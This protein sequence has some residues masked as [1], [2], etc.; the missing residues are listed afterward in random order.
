MEL[1]T[2][3]TQLFIKFG[4]HEYTIELK[5]HS[6]LIH[7]ALYKGKVEPVEEI[8]GSRNVYSYY[9]NY[10]HLFPQV[11]RVL[12]SLVSQ[13]RPNPK[14]L[15]GIY[16]KWFIT[17]FGKL[18]SKHFSPLFNL[19]HSMAESKILLEVDKIC[20]HVTY[21]ACP[22]R[23]EI[24]KYIEN[25]PDSDFEV[26][27][28]A[29]P[30]CVVTVCNFSNLLSTLGLSPNRNEGLYD[31]FGIGKYGFSQSEH[32]IDYTKALCNWKVFLHPSL[33]YYSDPVVKSKVDS[34]ISYHPAQITKMSLM[35]VVQ[36]NARTPDTI[37]T[38]RLPWFL[39]G[40][41]LSHEN[42]DRFVGLKETE[43]L[44]GKKLFDQLYPTLPFPD[45]RLRSKPRSS[46][47]W[48]E[49]VEYLFSYP[50]EIPFRDIKSVFSVIGTYK[51][52]LTLY[53]DKAKEY[54][55]QNTTDPFTTALFS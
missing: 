36:S 46:A 22:I 17:K 41:V 47:R 26:D 23:E 9:Y 48:S 11:M 24:A 55:A 12:A 43:I 50:D 5:P 33:M 6:S 4:K 52:H 13:D 3:Y 28:F 44:K 27:F 10:N 35:N 39:S 20:F 49:Y 16:Q 1:T 40:H 53:N 8:S 21:E 7:F 15:E 37:P 25:N 38:N 14:I 2:A 34:I 31:V 42:Y 30:V 54:V 45:E 51:K 32:I 19:A 29:S 18:V